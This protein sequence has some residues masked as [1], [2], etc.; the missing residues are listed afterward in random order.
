[1]IPSRRERALRRSPGSWC[2]QGPQ[3]GCR[4]SGWASRRSPPS[5]GAHRLSQRPWWSSWALFSGRVEISVVQHSTARTRVFFITSTQSTHNLLSLLCC[6]SK[7]WR[8][9]ETLLDAKMGVR[10]WTETW[11][12]FGGEGVGVLECHHCSVHHDYNFWPWCPKWDMSDKAIV[13]N[14]K[15]YP[16]WNCCFFFSFELVVWL[17]T[18]YSNN[19][20]NSEA[21]ITT[22][23]NLLQKLCLYTFSVQ[24]KY[25]LTMKIIYSIDT[26]TDCRP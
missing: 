5:S 26:Q 17:W 15:D 9:Q 24:Y 25:T 2:F 10:H 16:K 18:S 1:M 20:K 13:P 6:S 4:A 23:T 11:S 3:R 14:K 7:D 12:F 22:V 8:S 19:Y 21:E